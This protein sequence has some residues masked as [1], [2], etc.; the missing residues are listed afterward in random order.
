VSSSASISPECS[1]VFQTGPPHRGPAVSLAWATSA[2]ST[3]HVRLSV[4]GRVVPLRGAVMG[5]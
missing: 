4:K 5:R 3:A 2:E 1:M